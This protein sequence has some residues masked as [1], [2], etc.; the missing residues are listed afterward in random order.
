[1]DIPDKS[2]FRLDEVAVILG[3]HIRTVQNYVADRKFD[4]IIRLGGQR[5]I[6]IPHASLE[7]FLETTR[8]KTK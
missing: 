6:R 5:L 7:R 3:V 4:P 1:M 2:M 8:N